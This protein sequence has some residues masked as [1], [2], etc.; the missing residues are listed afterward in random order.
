NTF[1]AAVFE[2]KNIPNTKIRAGY[3]MAQKLRDH[4]EFHSILAYDSSTATNMSFKVNGND[5]SGVHKGLS[6]SNISKAHG[7]VKPE[8]VL[9]TAENKSIPN[10]TLNGEYIAI[11]G[12][13]STAIA[14]A[15]YQIG[16]GNGWSLTPGVRYLKQMDDGAGAIGGAALN[17][18][19]GSD[20]TN[21]AAITARAAYTNPNSVDGSILMERLVLAKGP[22]ALMAGYSAV[23]DNADIIAPWRGFPTGG[24]TRSMAQVNWIANTK[25]WMVKADYDFDKA[26]L[27]PGLKAAIDYVDMNFDEKKNAALASD[28]SDRTIL[29]VDLIQEFKALPNTEFKFRFATV[30]ADASKKTSS[31]LATDYESYN[32]YR[33]EVNYLF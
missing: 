27:V 6:V 13:F 8:M 22:F 31:N 33:F 26:G 10:L 2:N 28:F 4:Q 23:S 30:N 12:F 14:E 5:D 7:D 29:H 32:E 20:K 24:Y 18:S 11:S 3:I 15:N 16:L 1:E 25:S 17:G 21:A 19:M 9:V